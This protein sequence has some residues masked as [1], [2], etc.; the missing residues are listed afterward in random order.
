MFLNTTD[1]WLA[2][3]PPAEALTWSRHIYVSQ[4]PRYKTKTSTR[5]DKECIAAPDRIRDWIL[6]KEVHDALHKAG[7]GTAP[8]L[9]YARGILNAPNPDPVAFDRKKCNLILIKVGF[10]RDFGCHLKLHDKTNKYAP[11]VASLQTL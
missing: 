2:S 7:H 4:E 11:L 9:I 10:C 3:T 1:G 6:P 5:R 8:D